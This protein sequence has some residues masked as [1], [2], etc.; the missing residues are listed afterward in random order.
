MIVLD[1]E[2]DCILIFENDSQQNIFM[3]KMPT[4]KQSFKW[5]AVALQVVSGA[6]TGDELEVALDVGELSLIHI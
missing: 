2:Y 5:T 4:M 6:G 3:Q 1:Y